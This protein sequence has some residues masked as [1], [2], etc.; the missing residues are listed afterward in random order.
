M[1]IFMFLLKEIEMI[2][3]RD[4]YIEIEGRICKDDDDGDDDEYHHEENEYNHDENEYH[5]D[6]DT[7]YM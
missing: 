7:D 2:L 1:V 3:W 6:G 5:H 4:H